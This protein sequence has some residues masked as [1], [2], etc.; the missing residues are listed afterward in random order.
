MFWFWFAI[1][2][3]ILGSACSYIARNRNRYTKNWFLMGFVFGVIALAVLVLLP[4]HEYES[5]AI[6]SSAD[7]N[8]AR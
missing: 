3:M 5:D 8:M 6:S 2:G 7:L 1:H 4:Y